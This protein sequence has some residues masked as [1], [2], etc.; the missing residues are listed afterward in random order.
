MSLQDDFDDIEAEL[1]VVV[2]ISDQ[3][4]CTHV[5]CYTADG[6]RL[7]FEFN[8]MSPSVDDVRDIAGYFNGIRSIANRRPKVGRV[9]P[10]K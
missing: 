6:D 9:E 10:D 1:G 4:G 7:S 5:F 3:D 8:T 2:E